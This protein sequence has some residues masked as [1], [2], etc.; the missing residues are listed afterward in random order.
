M[1]TFYLWGV[2]CRL[3]LLFPALLT[4]LLLYQ[5][6]GIAAGC[7]LAALLHEGG[8]LLAMRV[9]GIPPEACVVGMFG[10]RIRLGS[11][12]PG[13]RQNLLISLAGPF[14]NLFCG[15]MLWLWGRE[16]AA[17]VHGGMALFNLLPVTALDGGELIRCGLGLLGWERV[18]GVLLRV[19]TAVTLLPLAAFS[20]WLYIQGKGNPTLCVVSGYF[21]TLVFFSDKMQKNT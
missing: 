7:L 10:A 4:A 11:R 13:Y 12:L 14:T 18:S 16:S 21:V 1:F 19:T 9:L 17:V 15:G 8:H 6:E 2:R 5:P 3:S 20:L